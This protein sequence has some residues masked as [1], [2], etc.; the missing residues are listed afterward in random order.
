MNSCGYS[1]ESFKKDYANFAYH[2][3]ACPANNIEVVTGCG[4]GA[5]NYSQ[6]D[7]NN[8]S[9]SVCGK[10]Y[11]NCVVIK[12]GDKWVYNKKVYENNQNTIKMTSMIDKAKNTCKEL[13]FNEGTEKF[14]DCS[15][16]LYTQQMELAVT[17]NQQ[18]VIQ[19][20]NSG[21]MTIYDPV[22][23]RE[24]MQRRALG[25]INGTCTL[26]NYINC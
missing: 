11:S 7:A 12:E 4:F 13:G 25:L 20:G 3:Y 8:K 22:R 17:Q 23:D 5:S 6:N 14:T 26:A 15:L 19:G 9:L 16:K 1:Y 10:N 2:S 24:N 18:V 21:T